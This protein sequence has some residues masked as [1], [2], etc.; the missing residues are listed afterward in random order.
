MAETA[1]IMSPEKKVYLPDMK[2]GCSLAESITAEDIR[3]LKK[4]S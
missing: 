1:K 3:K 2:A 4:I